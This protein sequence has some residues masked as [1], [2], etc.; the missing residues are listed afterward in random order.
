M[1]HDNVKGKNDKENPRRPEKQKALPKVL[2]RAF[3]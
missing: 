1:L 2:G 3:F